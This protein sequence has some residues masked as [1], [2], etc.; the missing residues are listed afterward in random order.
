MNDLF[1]RV[2]TGAVG[3]AI[4]C[5][6]ILIGGWVLKIGV[7]IVSLGLCH[8]LSSAFKEKG[9]YI[10]EPL[11]LLGCFFHFIALSLEL[12]SLVALASSLVFLFI[13]F[14]INE[15]FRLNDAAVCVLTLVY[16][17]YFLFPII[18]MDKSIYLYLVFIIAF[19]TDTFA[20]LTGL[21]IGKKKLLPAVSPKK[22]VEGSI[23]GLMGALIMGSIFFI[24]T[25]TELNLLHILFFLLSSVA[26]QAGDLFASKIKRETGIK[27]FGNILP[28]HGGLLDRFDS[29]LLI[30]PMV[31]IL[32]KLPM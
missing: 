29:I 2:T 25:N 26:G 23:G 11:I 30:T 18:S 32:F 7:L 14:L 28:G 5:F 22:T 24:F 20:Y 4:L 12:P 21:T 10:P 1:S 15:N 19:S 17:P 27:D 9:Y 8:E 13:L 16:I 6:F 3:L 31:Y